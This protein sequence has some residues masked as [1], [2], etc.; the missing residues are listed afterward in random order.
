MRD[1]SGRSRGFAFL[2]FEDPAAVNAVMVRE[3][4][5]DGKIVSLS[6][7]DQTA[8]LRQL[9]FLLDRSKTSDS[10]SRAQ[11]DSKSIRW[12]LGSIRDK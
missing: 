9:S 2:T 3:H 11:S 1:A 5:L 6:D 8:R 7:R 10:S 12:G 4:Y